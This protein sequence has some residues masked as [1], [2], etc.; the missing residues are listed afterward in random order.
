MEGYSAVW[1]AIYLLFAYFAIQRELAYGKVAKFMILYSVISVIWELLSAVSILGWLQIFG[2]GFWTW[3]RVFGALGLS[4]VFMATS[5][6]FLGS[7]AKYRIWITIAAS[8]TLVMFVL[9]VGPLRPTSEIAPWKNNLVFIG[10]LIGWMVVYAI[11]G[12]LT[13]FAFLHASKPLHKNRIVFWGA[14]ILT[15]LLG[16]IFIFAGLN[17]PGSIL[18]IAGTFM[19]G[20]VVFFHDLLDLAGT[21]QRFPIV[22]YKTFVALVCMS[23]FFHCACRHSP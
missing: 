19:A 14:S 18:H 23:L 12:Y 4:V 11:L 17:I 3:Q 10:I 13:T 6:E 7:Q 9:M 16:D 8:W 15:N 5:F 1:A 20:Y 2:T 21:L 22:I